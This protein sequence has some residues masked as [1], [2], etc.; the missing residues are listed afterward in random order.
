M[1]IIDPVSD[2]FTRIRNAIR[3]KHVSLDIPH[4]KYKEK[5]IELLVAEG[6]IKSFSII[7]KDNHKYIKVNLKYVHNKS[8]IQELKNVSKPG[9]RYYISKS[10]IPKYLNGF[11]ICI[12]STPKGVMTGKQARVNNVGGEF[13]GVIS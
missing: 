3:V 11:G 1:L 5:I 12:L 13:L 7:K 2:L 9:S 4:S 6:Y 10:K 8:V